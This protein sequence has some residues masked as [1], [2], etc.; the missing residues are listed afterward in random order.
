MFTQGKFMGYYWG[1]G[2]FL[3]RHPNGGIPGGF[4][5]NG[6][7][8]SIWVWDFLNKKWIDS[9]RVEGPLQGVVDDPATFEPNAKLGI[10]TTYLYLSNK[11]GNI[12]F[13]NF[14]NA[15]VP[16]EVS[17]ETNAVIMLF[18]NGDYWETS[19][20]PIYGDVSDKADKDLTNVTDEDL[21]K[22]LYGPDYD[23]S[24]EAFRE[25]ITTV[26]ESLKVINKSAIDNTTSS[27]SY[28]VID[29]QKTDSS[30]LL[31]LV[32]MSV[33]TINREKTYTQKL[34]GDS[35][36]EVLV[37]EKS[38]D[39]AWSEWSSPFVP[40]DLTNVDKKAI[41]EKVGIYESEYTNDTDDSR[42]FI[43]LKV[44]DDADNNRSIGIT[45][46]GEPF[47]TLLDPEENPER[48][49]LA[50]SD[51]SNVPAIKAI[52]V[53]ELDLATDNGCIYLVKDPNYMF[54]TRY[55]MTVTRVDTGSIFTVQTR[56]SVNGV[57]QRSK[58]NDGIWTSWSN[59]LKTVTESYDGLMPSTDKRKLDSIIPVRVNVNTAI[60]T[61]TLEGKGRTIPFLSEELSM[62]DIITMTDSGFRFMFCYTYNDNGTLKTGSLDFEASYEYTQTLS[63]YN[64]SKTITID[65]IESSKGGQ[66]NVEISLSE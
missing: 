30:Y 31:L 61:S 42:R 12:T 47:I 59:T 33:N 11:P 15:G 65:L 39:S 4:F 35:S 17:T 55:M 19:V 34:F 43:A 63:F 28:I 14:L 36:G 38:G 2:A 3:S 51:L 40:V 5:V 58:G 7:T 62:A 37:R 23:S 16:I 20:V 6:E 8:N 24:A 60:N 54:N 26:P 27:G 18:W 29:K 64:A 48:I 13:A 41:Q 52:D 25:F 56:L 21:V 1:V 46:E 44:W 9:N 49:P 22:V 32:D 53:S 66:V 10:K 50:L 57:E 45:S